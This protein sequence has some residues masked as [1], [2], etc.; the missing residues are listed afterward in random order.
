ME[1]TKNLIKK[2]I[3]KGKFIKQYKTEHFGYS[4]P[5]ADAIVRIYECEGKLYRVTYED[6]CDLKNRAWIASKVEEL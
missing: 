2:I 1:K 6:N 3:K 4:V 5:I